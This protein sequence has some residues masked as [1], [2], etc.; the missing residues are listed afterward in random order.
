MT[1]EEDYKRF[2]QK[3]KQSMEMNNRTIVFCM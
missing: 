2:E 1:F 3:E